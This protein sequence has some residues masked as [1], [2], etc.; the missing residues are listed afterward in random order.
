ML[1]ECD[2]AYSVV[3]E[4]TCY[5]NVK[6][7]A[8]VSGFGDFGITI[9]LPTGKQNMHAGNC[10]D[11]F[12]PHNLKCFY[13]GATY[14]FVVINNYR[15]TLYVQENGSIHVESVVMGKTILLHELNIHRTEGY[16]LMA[17]RIKTACC[18][19]E[20][21][22]DVI[23]DKISEALLYIVD[24]F[25]L[26]SSKFDSIMEFICNL[27]YGSKAGYSYNSLELKVKS[28]K[29]LIHYY[30]SKKIV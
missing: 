26:E 16:S 21:Y 23:T 24:A 5:Y 7:A 30:T 18:S 17:T 15:F 28:S 13:S 2:S 22:D 19:W 29:E 8:P 25:R 27:F 9:K 14:F 3:E 10:L 11:I 1:I 20:L 12:N 4:N 6:L